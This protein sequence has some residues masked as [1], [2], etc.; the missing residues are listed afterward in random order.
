MST[1]EFFVNRLN[2]EP[3]ALMFAGQSTPWVVAV[4][5]LMDDPELAQRLIDHVAAAH[6]LLT[7]VSAQLLAT[8]GRETDLFSFE[9][10]PAKL[11]PA[12]DATA[13]I[14][15]IALAQLGALLDLDQLGYTLASANPVALLGHSQGILGVHMAQAIIDAGSIE[16]ARPQIDEILAIAALIGAA[17]TRE[18]RAHG[19][20]RKYGDATPML[21]VKGILPA[22]ADELIRRVDDAR[23]PIAVAVINSANHVVLSG[24]PQDLASFAVEVA[25]E[26]KHQAQLR[27]EKVRGGSVFD[28]VLEYLE[29]TLPFHSPI[30]EQAVEQTVAWAE[31]CGIDVAR[32]RV[33][34]GE[35]LVNQVDWSA[36]VANL[37]K[38][39][40]PRTLWA[41]DLGPGTTLAKLFGTVAE[42]TGVGVV[43]AANVADRAKL[44]TETDAPARM[45]D[46]TQY[47]PQVVRTLQGERIETAFTRLTGKPPVLLAGMTPTTVD[48]EIVAAAANAGYWAELAGGGQVTAPGNSMRCSWTSTCGICSSAPPASCRRSVPRA[49]RSTAW[50]SPPAS[51]SP[52]RRWLW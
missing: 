9:A 8:T 22:Q 31:E 33:L 10:N 36:Q 49:P 16:A 28:P 29:V 39:N 4:K 52:T 43:E 3:H 45:Q 46:W 37:F 19:L 48:P 50:S 35:V 30:M 17:G 40:D 13:S 6:D 21:S 26:H 12:A 47:V 11:G 1:P 38:E 42:G 24:H 27:A 23:G 20:V 51:P 5:Q 15:G 32:A 44:A 14:E 34:A 18:A 25:K 41:V 7:P 2:S